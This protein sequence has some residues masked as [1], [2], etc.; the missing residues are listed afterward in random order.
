MHAIR[1]IIIRFSGCFF[2][3]FIRT[4]AGIFTYGLA[5]SGFPSFDKRTYVCVRVRIP[6]PYIY[7]P[8]IVTTLSV[9]FRSIVLRISYMY[10]LGISP[11]SKMEYCIVCLYFTPITHQMQ[12]WFY[13]E[14]QR[15][16]ANNAMDSA[17]HLMNVIV[18][19]VHRK[20]SEHKMVL[21]SSIDLFCYFRAW[22][23]LG[24][25]KFCDQILNMIKKMNA[26]AIVNTDN[27]RL[28]WLNSSITLAMADDIVAIKI[29][30]AKMHPIF[31]HLT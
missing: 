2:L 1:L 20:Y 11:E 13:Y 5:C 31:L 6:F 16:H 19:F 29:E 12:F 7:L 22:V 30:V 27:F 18:R 21:H 8:N 3:P 14:R 9:I 4:H 23:Q 28:Q 15:S 26:H 25:V 10:T 24:N 17:I